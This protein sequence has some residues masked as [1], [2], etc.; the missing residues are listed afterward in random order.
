VLA[1]AAWAFLKLASEMREGETAP[2]DSGIL[3]ALRQPGDPHL[4][5]GPRW[6]TETMRDITALGG[7]TVLTLVAIVAVILL[8]LHAKR[9][10]AWTFAGTMIFAQIATEIVKRIY[11]RPRPGFAIYDLPVSNSF[12]SGHT[13]LS[14]VT[15]FLLAAIIARFETAPYTKRVVFILAALLTITIGASR[16]FLGVHWPSD[17]LAGWALGGGLALLAHHL[18]L[19]TKIDAKG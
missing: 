12:P 3:S 8:L 17:V 10:E 2:F 13:T 16:V 9:R 18:L 1:A 7:V 6:L 11:D 14:T 4:P 15:Y 19:R 5:I